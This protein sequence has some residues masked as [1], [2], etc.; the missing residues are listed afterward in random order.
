MMT[1]D[2]PKGAVI[3]TLER[4]L[5]LAPCEGNRRNSEGDFILLK[6]GRILFV[7]SRYGDGSADG[8]AADLYAIF[9]SDGGRSF[10]APRLLISR[11]SL[12]ADNLMS[13][14]LRRMKNGDLGL[15][16]LKKTA[17]YQCRLYLMR[18][19]DEGV[20]FSRPVACIPHRGYFVV[21]NDRII[22][23]RSG[24]WLVPAAC[25]EV[26]I[27]DGTGD[28]TY[29]PA[30]LI[31]YASDDDGATWYRKGEA[32]PAGGF[33]KSRTGLQEP[34]LLE[35]SDGTLWA[36]FRTDTGWQYESFSR[37]GGESW[38][39][40]VRSCFTAPS[41]PLSAER[42]SDGSI[43]AIWNPVPILNGRTDR[44][45]RYGF[46]TGGRTP[47]VMAR[48]FD[49]GKTFS[50]PADL[51]RDPDLGYAYVAIRELPDRSV[52]LGYCAG[53]PGDGGMLN[54]LRIARL[55]L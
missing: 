10:S 12:G 38:T 6:D 48:S 16:F 8:D 31:V 36:W 24:T 21:N 7:Y 20:T 22:L 49:A 25:T 37:D 14:T 45:P 41:S 29:G 40:P 33:E 13:V 28:G 17:P 3:L 55:H 2:Q 34:G 44:S 32:R 52:L 1:A 39:A 23:T 11:G 43:L 18:S 15:F 54:R 42:L 27:D 4:I 30:H 26:L 35:L 19:S 53:E 47:L 9:S 5:D 51:E 50:A 46:W